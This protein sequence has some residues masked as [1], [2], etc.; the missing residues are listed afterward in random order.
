[1]ANLFSFVSAGLRTGRAAFNARKF[2]ATRP[3]APR[4]VSDG[5]QTSISFSPRAQLDVRPPVEDQ[6]AVTVQVSFEKSIGQKRGHDDLEPDWAPAEE[7]HH[8]HHPQQRQPKR[9]CLKKPGLEAKF[10][11]E[12]FGGRKAEA[13]ERRVRFDLPP[14]SP[15]KRKRGENDDPTG[16]AKKDREVKRLRLEKLSKY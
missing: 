9:P 14:A 15:P 7:D 5:V 1:M 6:P 10:G 13:K 16:E 8:H 12:L 3:S 2:W 4:T 11:S